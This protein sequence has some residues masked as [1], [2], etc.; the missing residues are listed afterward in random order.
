MKMKKLA[1]GF[2]FKFVSSIRIQEPEWGNYNDANEYLSRDNYSS[3]GDAFTA[4]RNLQRANQAIAS[5]NPDIALLYTRAA[6]RFMKSDFHLT[7]RVGYFDIDHDNVDAFERINGKKY[8][9]S[10]Q[11][12]EIGF[13][14]TLAA[15]CKQMER[16]HPPLTEEQER[17][18]SFDKMTS[19]DYAS[20]A[21]NLEL[22]KKESRLIGNVSKPRVASKHFL[23]GNFLSL[24]LHKAEYYLRQDDDLFK[25]Y[26]ACLAMREYS[27]SWERVRNKIPPA[28]IPDAYRNQFENGHEW[29]TEHLA[30]N[31]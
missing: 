8:N 7:Q 9:R 20:L 14:W 24:L 27:P 6:Y 13:C 2:L 17:L 5:D 12:R 28:L 31:L 30:Q 21:E 23:A 22:G 19:D 3:T 1:K 26:R 16:N 29:N 15:Y 4:V 18:L 25:F 10:F 11:A